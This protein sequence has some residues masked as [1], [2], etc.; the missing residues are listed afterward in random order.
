MRRRKFIKMTVGAEQDCAIRAGCRGEG[1]NDPSK[2]VGSSSA[3]VA[4]ALA[5]SRSG[6][7]PTPGNCAICRQQTYRRRGTNRV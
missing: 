1:N 3:A 7:G 6:N 5:R 2:I 4:V